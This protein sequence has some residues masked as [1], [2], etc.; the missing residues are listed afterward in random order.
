MRCVYIGSSFSGSNAHTSSDRG[1]TS[2]DWSAGKCTAI[3]S[4][5]SNAPF[6]A[7][8][9]AGFAII[10][11][12]A[13][14][15]H[16]L[17]DSPA[18]TLLLKTTIQ[19]VVG[20][21]ALV[22]PL[23]DEVLS[24]SLGSVLFILL[25]IALLIAVIVSIAQ[26][27]IDNFPGY[28]SASAAY[29]VATGY[30]SLF[31]LCLTMI[32]S[33]KSPLWERVLK[34]PFE[35]AIKYHK[36][37]SYLAVW[38]IAIHFILQDDLW[39][40]SKILKEGADYK[41]NE[42]YPVYGL[43]SASCF[44]AMA[45][46]A[47]P[48][49][50]VYTYDIFQKVHILFVPGVVFAI[51]HVPYVAKYIFI[52]AILVYGIDVILRMKQLLTAQP[53]T[54]SCVGDDYV[55]LVVTPKAIPVTKEG[56]W[57]WVMIPEVSAAEFH[58]FSVCEYLSGGAFDFVIKKQGKGSWTDNL[59][60][61]VSQKQPISL[62]VLGPYGH[63][64]VDVYNPKYRRVVLV[65]GGVGITAMLTVLDGFSSQQGGRK[66]NFAKIMDT[67]DKN[68]RSVNL[69]FI[70]RSS[71]LMEHFKSRIAGICERSA[72]S[73]SVFIHLTNENVEMV[74]ASM[75]ERQTSHV[76]FVHG[77]PDLHKYI[78]PD[79]HS[80]GEDCAV[81]VCGPSALTRQTRAI[82]AAS[83]IDIHEETFSF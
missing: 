53:V 20:A 64:K 56:A 78:Q 13:I 80:G 26:D 25:W 50:R 40:A 75:K 36:I 39:G 52:P 27:R 48:V 9:I 2:V 34:V 62:K 8:A 76:S 51:L 11:A 37:I 41:I 73:A 66:D 61:R 77:R 55:H 59:H 49:F 22:R 19:N 38:S 21:G 42:A 17:S 46:F 32:T 47:F 33:T 57:Y 67:E 58:P 31:L 54:A 60:S 1:F 69:V 81:C 30:A 6:I 74:S 43:V 82:C 29:S 4:T 83:N 23:P 70:C 15:V 72:I 35:R 71:A 28:S 12:A 5:Q 14:L 45:F 3:T 7:L 65:A 63:L 10:A 16:F 79:G 68:H 24:T 44:W 18:G